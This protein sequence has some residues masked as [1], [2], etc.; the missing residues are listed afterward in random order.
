MKPKF[1]IILLIA[2]APGKFACTPEPLSDQEVEI[3]PLYI[4]ADV[5]LRQS[6]L[7]KTVPVIDDY[8]FSDRNLTLQ[9]KIE[10]IL[11]QLSKRYFNN[12]S[13]EM[14]DIRLTGSLRILHIDLVENHAYQ[15]PGSLQ[16]YEAWY[17]FF[18]GSHGGQNT[19]IIL[20]ESLLQRHHQGD[21]ID[22]LVVLYEGKEFGDFDHI[23]LKRTIFRYE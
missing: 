12:L 7:Q 18:Q 19:Q 23:D 1:I 8:V 13:V 16:P 21:W 2:I 6:G 11:E 9:K 4:A 17:D 22:A 15:G 10:I 3:F 14:N 20:T 5:E